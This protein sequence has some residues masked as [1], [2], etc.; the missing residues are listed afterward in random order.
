[1]DLPRIRYFRILNRTLLQSE[2][3][4]DSP[5]FVYFPPSCRVFF[6]KTQKTRFSLN[7]QHCL[8]EE[9]SDLL[10]VGKPMDE[11]SVPVSW[12]L[13]VTVFKRPSCECLRDN[14]AVFPILAHSFGPVWRNAS[15]REREVVG[16]VRN[17]IRK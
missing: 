3:E 14:L 13:W 15:S 8:S 1:M 2:I 17:P 5:V 7:S 6:E 10:L 11:E 16:G 4:D 12:G 9:V